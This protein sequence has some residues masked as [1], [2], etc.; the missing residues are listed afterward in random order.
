MRSPRFIIAALVLAAGWYVFL[1]RNPIDGL[2]NLAGKSRT[3]A[4]AGVEG[5]IEN[6]FGASH[7]GPPPAVR[8]GNTLRIASYNIQVFGEKK[9][10]HPQV[11]HILAQV[12]RRF[13]VVAI[14]EVRA[15]TQ[16][17]LPRFVDMI[18]AEG[19]HYDFVIGPRLGRSVS[20]EQ[21]AFIYDRASIE[22]DPESVY[23]V[24]DPGDRLQRE[25]L[26]AAFRARGPPSSEAFTFTLVDI[27]TE[28]DDV[29]D[30]LD[31]L[32]DAV[33][34]V[35]NDG[36][37][38]DDVILL[39]DLNADN[40]H[41]HGLGQLPFLVCAISGLPSNTHG[42]HLY[43]NIIFDRRATTEFTGRSGVFDIMRE[44]NLTMD[45]ALLVS[46]HLPI[47]AEF[48]TREGG[49]PDHI[50]GRPSNVK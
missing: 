50:A 34:A 30:E 27:H 33:H 35:R 17:V 32:A 24:N 28:P 49:Q 45:E 1:N 12:V 6:T 11:M 23:T 14:Q 4:E 16:D 31:A 46:D 38:E 37:Q 13:D 20:K 2:S 36:R 18:N 7:S 26:V 19:A 43:D 39:G 10:D 25:P 8:Q 41:L 9:L 40:L 29:A 47:W 44:F 21:Y 48:S 42:T 5:H 22:I 3:A 15:K